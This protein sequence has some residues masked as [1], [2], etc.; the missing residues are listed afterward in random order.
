MR[1]CAKRAGTGSG[2]TKD[3][4]VR[5]RRQ[6]AVQHLL[7][8]RA[9]V[10]QQQRDRLGDRARIDCRPPSGSRIMPATGTGASPARSTVSVR[11]VPAHRRGEAAARGRDAVVQLRL[12]VRVDAHDRR[13]TERRRGDVQA[14][15][16]RVGHAP[17]L[18]RCRR[19]RRPGRRRWPSSRWSAAGRVARA[20]GQADRIIDRR[21]RQDRDGHR[22][23]DRGPGREV[24]LRPGRGSTDQ[25]GS[26]VAQS[27]VRC[28][29]RRRAGQRQGAG[30]ASVRP[31]STRP[32][33]AA[34]VVEGQGH[35]RWRRGRGPRPAGRSQPGSMS[36]VYGRDGVD[37]QPQRHTRRQPADQVACPRRRRRPRSR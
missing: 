7:P 33:P 17:R 1:S 18:V 21:V 35:V 13:A 8:G 2:S 15:Q 20:D 22:D 19:A 9:V 10:R 32:P 4:S 26:L 24:D 28:W 3:W 34:S 31:T 27:S 6:L 23:L 37:V 29:P 30:H 5:Q 12:G 11:G 25:S 14:A 16:Q 36:R